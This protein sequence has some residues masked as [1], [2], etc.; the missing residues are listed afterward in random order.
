MDIFRKNLRRIRANKNMTQE[1]LAEKTG[2]SRIGI[3][4]LESGKTNTVK[5]TT[6]EIL[7]IGLDVGIMELLTDVSETNR[8][9][10]SLKVFIDSELAKSAKITDNEIKFLLSIPK[11]IWKDKKPS[12]ATFYEF[13]QGYRMAI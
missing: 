8:W 5:M 7:A 1:E 12:N 9:E 3:A 11:N 10:D 6:V 13:I 4:Q 2:L